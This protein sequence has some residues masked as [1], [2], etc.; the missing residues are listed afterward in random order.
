MRCKVVARTLLILSVFNFVLAA[1]VAVRKVR[2][3]SADAMGGR[4]DTIIVS[5]KRA[6]LDKTWYVQRWLKEKPNS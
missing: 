3:S 4:E 1:P 5:G 2:E 6:L